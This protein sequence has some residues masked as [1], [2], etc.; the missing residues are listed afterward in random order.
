MRNKTH[1]KNQKKIFML[2]YE[3]WDMIAD[4][5]IPSLALIYFVIIGYKIYQRQ[6]RIVSMHTAITLLSSVVVY[7]LMFFDRA[8]HIWSQFT[9]DYST[10]T[11]LALV[12]V[13]SIWH[14]TSNIKKFLRVYVGLSFVSYLLLMKWMA[15]H[16][17]LDMLTTILALTPFFVIIIIFCK[18]TFQIPHQSF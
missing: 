16:S 11:A 17:A 10:H 15:Y 14:I 13:H 2:T 6:Y 18:K 9:L 8:M 1:N 7:G 3:Q 12:F 4:A 5:Y